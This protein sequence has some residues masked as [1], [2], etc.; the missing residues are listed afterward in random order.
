[1]KKI[2]LILLTSLPLFAGALSA[3][4]EPGTNLDRLLAG[5]PQPWKQ[6]MHR[7]T[8]QEYEATL[9]YWSERHGKI[10]QVERVAESAEKMPIFLLKITDSTVPD[11]DKQVCLVTALHGGPERSGTTTILHLAEWLLGGSDEAAET[12]RKQVLLL[13]PIVNPYAFFVTDRFGTSQG[14]NPYGGGDE[15]WDLE[16]LSFKQ[17]DKVPEIRAVLS[18]MDRYRP[19]VHADIHGTGL[20]EYPVDKLGD[21]RSYRGQTMF[22]S[23]GSAYSNFLLRPWD[24]RITDAMIQAGVEAGY[25]SDR[26]EAD[27][28]RGFWAPALD[29][30]SGR[31]WRGRTRFYTAQIGYARYHTL[32]TVLEVGWE[33][34]GVARLKGLLLIGNGFWQDQPISGYPVNRVKSFTGHYVTAWGRTAAERRR[35]RVELWEKQERFLQGILYPQTA[36]RDSYLVAVDRDA[37][38]VL[39]SDPE[40][41]LSNLRG[42]PGIDAQSVETFVRAGPEV[43]VVLDRGN[44]SDAPG[45]SRILHGIGF[46]FRIPY[47]RPQLVD[48]RLNGHAL[49]ESPDDGYQSWFGNGFTQVQ[50]NVPPE[51]ARD[52]RIFVLTVAY[53]P[54]VTRSYGWTPPREVLDRLGRR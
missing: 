13:M 8:L 54:D 28:Q 30:L 15:N 42:R 46:R 38:R 21:R 18:V 19:E 43:L 40:V 44:Q 6:K 17:P 16:N 41:F 27:A 47:R 14:M 22:E 29:A 37:S 53:R 1:M 2:S 25:G 20:Q 23:T 48:V 10:L 24:P 5:L 51:K 36:G 26:A 7:I 31:L 35:S 52:L 33:E 32:Q 39:D 12:R 45:S 9:E 34:A 49:T 11:E 50:V 3:S 4:Q